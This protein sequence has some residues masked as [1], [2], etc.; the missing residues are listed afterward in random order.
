MFR[1]RLW[2]LGGWNPE[3]QVRFPNDCNSEVWSSAD[4]FRWE[5]ACPAAPW[6]KRHTAG[7]A[8]HRG[9]MWVVGGD[10]IQ[11][12][13]QN[14]V[15]SS[16]DGVNWTCV[17]PAAP[18][19]PRVLHYTVVHAGKL[20]VMGG[21]TL[22][23]FAPAPPRR[24][25]DVWSSEDGIRWECVQPEAPWEPRGQIGGS[26][27]KDGWIWIIGGGMYYERYYRD[28]WRSRDGVAWECVCRLAPWY[29]RYYHDVAV[30]DD[31]LWL[32]EGLSHAT[33]NRRDVWY[34]SDGTSWYEVPHT[35]WEP[36][37]AA[38]VFVHAG[39]LWVAAGN[40]HGRS[41]RHDVWKLT[42][43]P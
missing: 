34:S 10:P 17:Q 7:Y 32:L 12:H 11:G 38:S 15:W 43:V 42:P 1:D 2:L 18:W 41:C 9:R 28:V 25:R 3:D 4:G 6:E 35:P 30:F 37:H 8:V 26:A 23:D 13:Y 36:R 5:L 20:W 31:R 33:G 22:P 24:Y 40:R 21:Q 14:D 39:A 27:V 16:P 19:G 29:P